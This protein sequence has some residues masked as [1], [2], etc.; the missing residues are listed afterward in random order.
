[1]T[2]LNTIFLIALAF[3]PSILWL[4]FYL[5]K[6]AHPES[7]PMVIK[8]FLYGMLSAL[9]AILIQFGFFQW[10]SLLPFPYLVPLINTFLGVAFVEEYIKYLVARDKVFR[11]SELD[12]P[13][14]VML[15]M[16]IS[17]L[18]FAALEN[19]LKFLSPA[20]FNLPLQDTLKI[21]TFV[22]ISSTF[23]HA[24]SSGIFGFFLALGS[25]ETKK[26]GWYFFVGLSV[27]I[28][29]HGVYNFLILTENYPLNFVGP[30][31]IIVI[32]ATSV[33]LAIKRLKKIK[34]VCKI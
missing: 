34:S 28:I 22:F 23:L 7:N 29:S 12:E 27:A 1:M 19:I 26:R 13:L 24:L 18:G 32:L 30:L 3:L 8:I 25:Y 11:T 31:L 2:H 4:L 5:R 33:S 20:V 9:P 14:D 6:D 17:A 21:A 10:S 15:Y 16:I